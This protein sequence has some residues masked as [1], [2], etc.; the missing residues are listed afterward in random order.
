MSLATKN[1]GGARSRAILAALALSALPSL[2]APSTASALRVAPPP[3]VPTVDLAQL[4]AQL[5]QL[6]PEV[7]ACARQT[8]EAA[9]RAQV[10]VYAYPDG[11]WS[12]T[13]G[14]PRGTP[15]PGVRGNTAFEGCVANA[16]T[17]AIG[18]SVAPF[19]GR[20]PHKIS[21]RFVLRGAVP[22][23]AVLPDTVAAFN[24]GLVRRTLGTRRTAIQAC[25]PHAAR[26]PRT[27]IQIR[28]EVAAAGGV[29]VTGLQI[30]AHLDF[31]AVAQCVERAVDGLVGPTFPGILRGAVPFSVQIDRAPAADA[32]PTDAAATPAPAPATAGPATDAAATAAPAPAGGGPA[33]ITAR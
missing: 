23:V 2:G 13:F 33:A 6:E 19:A 29:R 11:Q 14:P 17:D 1:N 12:I 18:P 28:V 21:R 5:G 7:Q 20:R 31:P 16:L 3:P 27:E 32:A 10:N 22:T 8:S 15:P 25:F 9:A 24:S 30:P 26:A 4:R